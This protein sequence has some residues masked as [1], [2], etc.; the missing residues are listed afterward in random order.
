MCRD[1]CIESK[2]SETLRFRI[3]RTDQPMPVTR[4]PREESEWLQ[5]CHEEFGQALVV[6][7]ETRVIVEFWFV[8]WC[9]NARVDRGQP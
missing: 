2:G 5:A 6:G 4:V 7:Y 9:E 1:C 8:R 3:S